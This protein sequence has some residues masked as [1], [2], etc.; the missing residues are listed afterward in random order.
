MSPNTL[1]GMVQMF[2]NP[3]PIG[4][5]P[6][7]PKSFNVV[8]DGVTDDTTAV[9]AF[10]AAAALTN[11]QALLPCGKYKLTAPISVAVPNSSNFTLHGGGQDCT[12]LLFTGVGATGITF[13]Y[14]N[15]FSSVNVQDLTIMTDQAGATGGVA[16]HLLS[17]AAN[18]NPALAPNNIIENVTIIGSDL[19]SNVNYRI[20]G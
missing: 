8:G 16:L 7:T 3:P 12:R 9:K 15:N 14:G 20:I 13:T 11:G 10:F 1:P 4:G 2:G 5:I 17:T 19:Y 18:P 6:R